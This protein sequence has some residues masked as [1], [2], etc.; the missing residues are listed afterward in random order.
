MKTVIVGGGACGASCAARLRRLDEK[1]EILILEATNEISIANCGLPYYC[2]DVISSRDDMIVA[3]PQIFANLLNV[4]VR[5]NSKVTKINKE[6]KTVTVNDDYDIS[7]DNL[8]LALGASPLRP[9]IEGI[10]NSKIFT[11]RTL[12]DADRIKMHI[13]MSEA[14]NAVVIGGGFIGIEMAEN[15]IE[16]GLNTTLVEAAPQVLAPFDSDIVCY[17][18]NELE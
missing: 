13:K 5:L 9:N 18:Q 2:S 12:N 6:S 3:K 16:M 15:F 1:A 14:K 8:V 10:N 4:E 7:Y 11:V 17:A